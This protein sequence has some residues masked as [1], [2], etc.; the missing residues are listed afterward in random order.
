MLVLKVDMS[1]F[2]L[3]SNQGAALE[4]VVAVL[5]QG[6]V[7]SGDRRLIQVVRH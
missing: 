3:F 5:V 1:G 4:S 2:S 7:R 6:K